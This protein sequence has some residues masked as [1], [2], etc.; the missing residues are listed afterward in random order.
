MEE[1]RD[2]APPTLFH[3][4]LLY[5]CDGSAID[6]MVGGKTGDVHHRFNSRRQLTYRIAHRLAEVIQFLSIHSPVQGSTDVGTG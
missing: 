1:S 4:L 5:F 2:T 3:D 6:N